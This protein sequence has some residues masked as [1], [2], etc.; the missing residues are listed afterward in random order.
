MEGTLKDVVIKLND[1]K[2][3]TAC[4]KNLALHQAA[5]D[6]LRQNTFDELDKIENDNEEWIKK[7][8]AAYNGWL[9]M[10]DYG[11]QLDY[12]VNQAMHVINEFKNENNSILR[13]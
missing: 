7:C 1:G 4:A 10:A 11:G 6:E 9:I 13:K 12:L 2:F 3:D 5:I 8:N